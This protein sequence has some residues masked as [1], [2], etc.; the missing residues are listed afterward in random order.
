MEKGKHRHHRMQEACERNNRAIEQDGGEMNCPFKIDN[1]WYRGKEG[2]NKSKY[3][4]TLRE[5]VA[6]GSYWNCVG[7]DNCPL[8]E[9]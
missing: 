8:V 4:C 2:V 6:T 9:R 3:L 5:H 7:E 1:Y